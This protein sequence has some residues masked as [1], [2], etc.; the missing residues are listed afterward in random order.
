SSD[1]KWTGPAEPMLVLAG[2]L[3]ARGAEVWVAC[4]PPPPEADRSLAAE[5]AARALGPALVLAPGRAA[6]PLADRP[7]VA[8]LRAFLDAHDVEV[9]HCWHTRDHLLAL[10]AARA[11][12]RAGRTAVVRSWRAA[13]PLPRAPWQRWLLGPGADGLLVPSP[14]LA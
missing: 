4:P 6:R 7:D 10:R 11:R 9:V 12:R 3:R 13:E 14:A 2:A 1:W 5:A 8:R